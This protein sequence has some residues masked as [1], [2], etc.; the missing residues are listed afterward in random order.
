MDDGKFWPHLFSCGHVIELSSSCWNI[1]LVALFS[2]KILL[3]FLTTLSSPLMSSKLICSYLLDFFIFWTTLLNTDGSSARSS[4]KSR[5]MN[6]WI[7]FLLELTLRRTLFCAKYSTIWACSFE[8][9]SSSVIFVDVL[10]PFQDISICKV[11]NIFVIVLFQQMWN[12][13]QFQ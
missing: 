9:S 8:E 5:K 12:R 11:Q 10:N 6:E 7:V 1:N 2:L 3:F 4:W 13:I